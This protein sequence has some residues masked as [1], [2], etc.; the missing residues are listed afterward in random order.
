MRFV[1]FSALV[2]LLALTAPAGAQTPAPP[3]QTPAPTY[4]PDVPQNRTLY[5]NGQTGRYL[6]GGT[7]LYRADPKD[8]GVGLQFFS[9]SSTAG[10][11]PVSVPHDWT[12]GDNSVE[13][14]NGSVGWYRKDFRVPDK[15]A[16]LSWILRFESVNYRAT[17]YLNGKRLGEHEGAH[18]AF[19]VPAKNITRGVN[20][21]VVRVDSRRGPQD[22]PPGGNGSDGLPRG[23]WWNGSGL[24]R[25]VYL[26]KVDQVDVE[27]V[28]VTPTLATVGGPASV[29]VEATL[30]NYANTREAVRVRGKYGSV[31]VD[32]GST[33]LGPGGDRVLTKTITIDKPKLWSPPSPNL[34]KVAL[35]AQGRSLVPVLTGKGKKRKRK[36]APYTTIG[37]YRELNGI[38]KI[39]VD[40]QGML[41]LNGKILNL[42]GFG[43]HEDNI[44]TG[45][46]VTNRLRD[47]YIRWTKELSGSIIRSHY[48]L[49]P[50]LLEQADKNGIMIFSEIPVWSVESLYLQ[51][52][53][54][55]AAALD[56]LRSNILINQDHPSV[57]IWSIGNELTSKPGPP[58][59]AWI[60]T[61]TRTAHKMD[62]TRPVTLA[63]V[64]YPP[65][66]CRTVY[67]SLDVISVNTYFGWYPAPVGQSADRTLLSSFL[68]QMRACYPDKPIMV[69]EFGAE[70]NRS[71]PPEEKGTYEFQ[72]DYVR[73]TAAVIAS[74]PFVN[75]ATYW[76]LQEFR[77]RPGYTG[78]NPRGEAPYHQK[79][80]ID[81]FGNARPIFNVLK[82]LYSATPQLRRATPD[83]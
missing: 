42:R 29:K 14:M 54:V 71:G 75:A 45:Q 64:G 28:H 78:G 79:G 49:S 38:R 47:S 70:G 55:R 8:E 66:E 44:I 5:D 67:K 80:P 36:L 51:R 2:L 83:R 25:E 16:G 53:S 34:Y 6:M 11:T 20:R 50:Y 72:D 62:P 37:G 23:G 3:A 46:A 21:L 56:Q 59:N 69:T 77:V 4:K 15:G 12:A 35:T 33:T 39:E 40:A 48:P 73:Y 1:P 31:P 43:L 7:W 65:D 76:T 57:L 9:R 74:K 58:E 82:E 32:L 26:R 17:V 19:E 13:S 61:A 81:R 52:D 68:D 60:G 63:L 18:L 22:L 27:S 41:T 24:L 30:R 10:W